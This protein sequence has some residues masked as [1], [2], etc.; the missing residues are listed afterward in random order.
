MNKGFTLVELIIVI[1]IIGIIASIAIPTITSQ[2]NDTQ[3]GWTGVTETRC[4]GGFKVV[5]GHAASCS[6][7]SIKTAT[8][9]PAINR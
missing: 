5:V 9:F 1:A 4:Q 6:N 2:S 7:W 8:A 3:F